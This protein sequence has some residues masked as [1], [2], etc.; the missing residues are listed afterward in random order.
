M[1]AIQEVNS[2]KLHV[3]EAEMRENDKK[4]IE[5]K[6]KLDDFSMVL[7]RNVC[8]KSSHL[9]LLGRGAVFCRVRSVFSRWTNLH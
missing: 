2:G 6:R 3:Q 8:S 9:A 7:E 5:Q 1:K 4:I